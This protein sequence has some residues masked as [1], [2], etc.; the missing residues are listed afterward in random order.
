MGY[1]NDATRTVLAAAT[2]LMASA[3]G[4]PA[5][6]ACSETSFKVET[7]SIPQTYEVAGTLCRKRAKGPDRTVLITAHGATYNRLYWD[8]PQDPQTYSFVR[9]LTRDVSVLNVDLL[10]SGKSSRPPSAQLTQQAQAA[11][12]HQLVQRMRARGFRKVVL[13]GHSSGSGTATLE[14]ATYHDVDGVIVTG[15]LHRLAPPPGGASVPLS[16]Y[17]A[18]LDPAFASLAL[19]PGYLTTRPG[20][21]GN[22]GFYN[23]AAADPAVIAFDDAHKDVVTVPQ[24]AG[25]AA[26]INDPSI[27]RAVDVP[28]LSIV[29]GHDGGFCDN[30]ECPQ[31]AE[32]GA[33]WSPAAQLELHVIP[34]AGHDIHL[35]ARPYAQAEYAYVRS[36]LRRQGL[37]RPPSSRARRSAPPRPG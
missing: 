9:N 13:V 25:F 32:E 36:W 2:M 26:I 35:H 28:V 17:P 15:F 19:D 29:G 31:A 22:P 27:S 4:S 3:P 8:W 5:H 34:T 6:A 24:I 7:G 21:R 16:M 10:G 11:M 37:S 33:A 18:A 23:V 30:P 1:F 12:L 20:T 14:A